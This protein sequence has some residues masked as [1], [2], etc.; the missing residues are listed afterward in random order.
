MNTDIKINLDS[1]HLPLTAAAWQSWKIIGVV[2]VAGFITVT[3]TVAVYTAVTLV[4]GSLPKTD[5]DRTR[6]SFQRQCQAQFALENQGYRAD[7]GLN[8]C[9]AKAELMYP[10]RVD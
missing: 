1:K 6:I 5:Q 4:K 10:S 2:F 3:A 9:K 8:L 7:V